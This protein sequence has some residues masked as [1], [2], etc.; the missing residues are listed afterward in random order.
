MFVIIGQ[1]RLEWDGRH[2]CSQ[3]PHAKFVYGTTGWKLVL[4]G[5]M[6][7]VGLRVRDVD[8]LTNKWGWVDQR[9]QKTQ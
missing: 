2:N 8:Q 1:K 5:C 3:P 9:L 4:A 6:F 7:V